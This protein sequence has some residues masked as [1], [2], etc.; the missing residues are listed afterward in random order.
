MVTATLAGAF[1]VASVVGAQEWRGGTARVEGSVRS[2]GGDPI[3]G[4]RVSLRWGQSDHGGPDLK[5]DKKGHWAV[6]GLVGGRWEADFAAPGYQTKKISVSLSEVSR[7]PNVDIRLEPEVRQAAQ[8]HEEILV[9]GRRVSKDAAAAIEAGN[10]ALEKKDYASARERYLAA[11]PDLPDNTALLMRIALAF[12]ADNK[13]DEALDYARQVL[14]KEPENLNARLTI[15]GIELERGHLDAAKEA[16]ASVPEDKI[17][18]SMYLNMGI[19]M[20]NKG[21]MAMAEVSFSKA[22]AK[23]A[24]VADSYYYRGLTRVQG[25]R[26]AEAKADFLKY[27]ELDPSGKEAGT[28]KAIL[29]TIK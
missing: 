29:D 15:A 27:L 8:V 1:L 6:L 5:T 2:A 12:E 20:F 21:N 18:D 10:A 28:V 9:G 4:A 13:P 22:I 7:N 14:Q 23:K 19:L 17:T 16:L 25:K 3:E 11:L 24:D 26:A